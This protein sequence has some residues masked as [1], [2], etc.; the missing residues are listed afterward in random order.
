MYRLPDR[1]ITGNFWILPWF[2]ERGEFGKTLTFKL[3]DIILS[4]LRAK[5]ANHVNVYWVHEKI[6]TAPIRSMEEGN[7]F[8]LFVSSHGSGGGGYSSVWLG[9]Q[10]LWSHVLSGGCP[11]YRPR[12]LPSLW[13]HVL[14]GRG[15]T[16]VLGYPLP[17]PARTGIPGTAVSLLRFHTGGLSCCVAVP[18]IGS[19]EIVRTTSFVMGKC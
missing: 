6:F 7:N 4:L 2:P 9:H 8:N 10:S 11:V 16:P 19:K 12:S 14:S 5:C 15:G 3:C 17:A 1:N 13:S 18:P